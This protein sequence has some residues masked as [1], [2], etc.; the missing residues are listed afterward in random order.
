MD[1][2]HADFY[3]MA[4]DNSWAE[5]SYHKWRMGVVLVGTPRTLGYFETKEEGYKR[6]AQHYRKLDEVTLRGLYR[7]RTQLYEGRQ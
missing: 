1:L 5:K 6:I 2:G 3:A 4:M 7:I